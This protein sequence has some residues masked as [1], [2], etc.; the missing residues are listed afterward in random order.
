[1]AAGTVGKNELTMK[2]PIPL[3]VG[4]FCLVAI[5]PLCWHHC[6]SR[7]AWPMGL[8]VATRKSDALRVFRSSLDLGRIRFP[9]Q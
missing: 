3:G 2:A 1:M 8:S 5:L 4:A 6:I 9:P 7:C